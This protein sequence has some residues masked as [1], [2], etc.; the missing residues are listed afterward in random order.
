MTEKV[1][2]HFLKSGKAESPVA[3]PK[4]NNYGITHGAVTSG[5]EVTA[6]A[7]EFANLLKDPA[8]NELNYEECL[9]LLV[10]A[11]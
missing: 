7:A 10:N 3:Q 4:A 1:T 5:R 6:M 11:K 8:F 2:K 9:D